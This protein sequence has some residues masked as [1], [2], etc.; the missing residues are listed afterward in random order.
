MAEWAG[1]RPRPCSRR[2]CLAPAL[3]AAGAGRA[4]AAGGRRRREEDRD[5]LPA[6][7]RL[8]LPALQLPVLTANGAKVPLVVALEH[9]MEEGHAITVVRVVNERDPVPSK[10]T[11]HFT[12]ANGQAYLALQVRLDQGVSE[13]VATASCN[14]HGDWST[15]GSVAVPD[16]AGGCAAPAPPPGPRGA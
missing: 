8:H 2:A 7:E 4:A 10:G 6:F 1:A 16:G 5:R 3:A 12:P 14:R 15:V 9:P 13:V 11:F